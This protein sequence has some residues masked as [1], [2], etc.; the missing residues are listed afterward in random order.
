MYA[1]FSAAYRSL[2]GGLH[3]QKLQ[4]MTML[5]SMPHTCWVC[6]T[7]YRYHSSA[8]SDAALLQS[9]QEQHVAD[10]CRAGLSAGFIFVDLLLQIPLMVHGWLLHMP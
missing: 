6:C 1:G 3:E 9:R 4:C 2:H 7:V 10:V 5:L 8:F